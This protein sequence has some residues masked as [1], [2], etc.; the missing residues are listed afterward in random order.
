M[1]LSS[2]TGTHHFF[3]ELGNSAG[4]RFAVSQQVQPSSSLG[5]SSDVNK[6]LQVYDEKA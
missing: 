6:A 5:K 4:S 2:V 3:G 1:R